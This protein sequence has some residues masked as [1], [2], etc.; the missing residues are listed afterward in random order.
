[1]VDIDIPNNKKQIFNNWRI[2]FQVDS[3]AD[4]VNLNGDEIQQNYTDKKLALHFKT[5]SVLNWPKQAMPHLKTFTVWLT[6]IRQITG[7]TRNGKI[8][9]KLGEWLVPHYKFRKYTTLIHKQTNNILI[10]EMDVWWKITKSHTVR[11]THFYA[12]TTRTQYTIDSSFQEYYPVD[13]IKNNLFYI[14]TNK[15]S[16]KAK[17]QI[18]PNHISPGCTFKTFLKT[19]NN[20]YKDLLKKLE[21]NDETFIYTTKMEGILM[22]SDGGCKNNKGSI[23]V[24]I[25]TGNKISMQLSSRV[26]DVYE[27]MNSH[28]SECNGLLISVQII[29]MLQQYLKYIKSIVPPHT[30]VLCCDNKSA[31]ETINKLRNKRINLKQQ[32]SPNMD[33]IREIILCL[34]QIKVNNGYIRLIHIDGHQDKKKKQLSKFAELNVQAD[35]LATQGLEKRAVKDIILTNDSAVIFIN[36]KKVTS[37][38]IK[39]LRDCYSAN[40]MYEYYQGKYQWNHTTIGKIWWEVHGAAFKYFGREQRV[41]IKKFIHGRSACNKRENMYY[42]YKSSMCKTC[43]VQVEDLYHVLKCETCS[44]RHLLR[45]KYITD[46]KDKMVYMGT[47]T[48]TIRVVTTYLQAWLCNTNYPTL[49]E[50]MPNASKHMKRAV[51]EQTDIGWNQWF[52]GRLSTT[53]GDMYNY[54][55]QKPSNIVR[56]PSSRRWGKEIIKLSWK[57]ML[58]CWYIRNECEH[59]TNGDPIGRAKEKMIE[60]IKWIVETKNDNIPV[61]IRKVAHAELIGQPRENLAMMLEQLHKIIEKK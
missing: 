31:V 45:K 3:I 18:A 11:S 6:L 17:I 30:I 48:D 28:R 23:G 25:Q 49:M 47:N 16:E 14:T 36:N 13:L 40:Q 55:I 5:N 39:H 53:W 21:I 46:L 12:Q 24:V 51:Q 59:D 58:D 20:I 26:P 41:T 1:V 2:F 61:E 34:K 22:G 42:S 9:N 32:M 38:Y 43:G 54:D 44:K 56:Y 57:F 15:I 7:A 29:H 60:E 52:H 35:F 37:H 33:I 8:C 27:E 19:Q 50:I 10:F 4:I